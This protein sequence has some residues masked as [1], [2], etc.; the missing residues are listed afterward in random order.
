MIDLPAAN[1]R[2]GHGT[3]IQAANEPFAVEALKRKRIAS[4]QCGISSVPHVLVSSYWT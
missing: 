4:V 2:L 1:G 3:A